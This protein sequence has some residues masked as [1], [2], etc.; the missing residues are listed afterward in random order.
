MATTVDGESGQF[1]DVM[2]WIRDNPVVAFVG[3]GVLFVA[4]FGPPKGFSAVSRLGPGPKNNPRRKR[5][6]R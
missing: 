3:A 2:N 1:D 4:I 6:W 5:G